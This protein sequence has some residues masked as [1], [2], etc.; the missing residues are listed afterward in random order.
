M[1]WKRICNGLL[2]PDIPVHLRD[3]FT[4]LTARHMRGQAR[5]LFVGF[6]LSLPMVVLG[7]SPGAGPLVAYGLPAAIFV[8]CALALA[9]VARP[10][11]SMNST[12]LI[13]LKPAT[14]LA[15][16]DMISS[17]VKPGPL[18]TT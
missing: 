18:A 3:D 17:A 16:N 14:R 2:G 13:F 15:T 10:L 7:A 12:S 6:I 8:L 1:S 11:W 4:L 9:S 5:L